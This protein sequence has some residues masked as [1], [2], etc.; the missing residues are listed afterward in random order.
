[1]MS[2]WEVIGWTIAIPMVLTALLFVFALT[3]AI[4][5]TLSK[6]PK[7]VSEHPSHRHLRIVED[8]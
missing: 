6:P 8:D 3:G 7:S 2:P 5:K 1:M 4:F